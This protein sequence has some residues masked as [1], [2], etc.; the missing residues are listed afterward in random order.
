[1][2]GKDKHEFHQKFGKHILLHLDHLSH[3]YIILSVLSVLS[4]EISH[5]G[6]IV[7]RLFIASL[8]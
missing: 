3:I 8:L 1:M 2:G 7:A 4:S 6:L 5:T